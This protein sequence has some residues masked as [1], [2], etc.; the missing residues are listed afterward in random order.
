MMII[1]DVNVYFS[2]MFLLVV[3]PADEDIGDSMV[4]YS[5]ISAIYFSR[6]RSF[7]YQCLHLSTAPHCTALGDR[8][9]LAPQFVFSV[10][11]FWVLCTSRRVLHI[12]P[13]AVWL[14]WD[15]FLCWFFNQNVN[16][17]FFKFIDCL[18]QNYIN[19]I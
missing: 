14:L 4:E 3:I 9:F 5:L 1:V 2:E 7:F 18:M 16:I 19:Y 11:C 17:L 8:S 15:Y 12:S 6:I 13:P 10:Q